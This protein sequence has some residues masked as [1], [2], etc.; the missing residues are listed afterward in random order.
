MVRGLV[1]ACVLLVGLGAACAQSAMGGRTAGMGNASLSSLG[2]SEAIFL[3]AAALPWLRQA[4]GSADRHLWGGQAMAA[5][6]FADVSGVP[7]CDA[8]STFLVG[9][10]ATNGKHGLAAYYAEADLLTDEL[11]EFGI[12]YGV[13]LS[14]DWSVGA[15]LRMWDRPG[16][17]D[18][19]QTT[20]FSLLHQWHLTTGK[21][22]TATLLVRDAYGHTDEGRTYDLGVSGYL[23]E[24]FLLALLA[25]DLT[26]ET[27]RLLNVGA[28]VQIRPGWFIRT[29]YEER[30]HKNPVGLS[31]GVGHRVR[32]WQFDLAF[33]HWDSSMANV[34]MGVGVTGSAT[35]LF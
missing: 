24:D 9:A 29:G 12:G 33:T 25:R 2:D 17:G 35:V 13:S 1:V 8:Q 30:A 11:S 34:D 4:A 14:H 27:Y 20:D 5:Y 18:D 31:L 16:D 26:N 7:A 21:P 15:M 28:E 22:L 19:V 32:D 10:G 3:N 6:G 23:S